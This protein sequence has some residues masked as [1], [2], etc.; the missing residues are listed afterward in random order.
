MRNL[1]RR[2]EPHLLRRIKEDV[3]TDIP[4]KEEVIIDVEL[5]TLQKKYYRAIFERN[6]AFLAAATAP[7]NAAVP[8]SSSSSTVH[9]Q[10]GQQPQ[11]NNIQM[12][13]RKCCNHPYMVAGVQQ[14]QMEKLEAKLGAA[15]C[16][17]ISPPLML[18]FFSHRAC[19][20][21][22]SE[23]CLLFAVCDVPTRVVEEFML[24][25]IC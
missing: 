20:S 17:S 3:A 22:L 11:L 12:E 21:P 5:T 7:G 4:A 2:L 1:Q 9:Q 15:A 18:S 8:S 10:R 25:L 13:L 14:E 19:H 6:R 16:E 23:P 24:G